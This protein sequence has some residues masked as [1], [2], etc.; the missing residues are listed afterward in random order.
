MT[1]CAFG[2]FNPV[3]FAMRVSAADERRNG[4]LGS[5][6][7][8]PWGGP[9]S[10]HGPVGGDQAKTYPVCGDGKHP[11]PLQH[12]TSHHPNTND[13]L[14]CLYG[15]HVQQCSGFGISLVNIVVFGIKSVH[16]VV[17]L[18]LSIVYIGVTAV[19]VLSRPSHQASRP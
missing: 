13:S 17:V 6:D 1:F 11:P 19:T 14:S 2:L 5:R 16:I 15:F 10:H 8:L 3:H 4:E 12:F 9:G 18:S 7:G